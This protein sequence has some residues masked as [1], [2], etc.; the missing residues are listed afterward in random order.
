MR[1]CSVS[2][3]AWSARNLNRLSNML[4]FFGSDLFSRLVMS[5]SLQPHGLQHARLPS[6]LLSPG[7]QTLTSIESVMPSNCLILCRPLL[8]LPSV[9][10]SIRV[11]SNVSAPLIRQPKYWSL[12]FSISPSSEYSGLISFTTDWF[13]LLAV[14]GAFGVVVS[15]S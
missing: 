6:P 4:L 12:S 2:L 3:S 11:F 14:Q 8:L 10:P 1:F 7:R 15:Y 13:D 9:S 5:D